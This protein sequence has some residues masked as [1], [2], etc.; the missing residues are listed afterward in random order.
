MQ[1]Y[2]R[3]T[4]DTFPN[5]PKK[6]NILGDNFCVIYTYT[7]YIDNN[8]INIFCVWTGE[9]YRKTFSLLRFIVIIIYWQLTFYWIRLYALVLGIYSL[10]LIIQKFYKLKLSIGI[11]CM[12]HTIYLCV[13][14]T[15]NII[16]LEIN[17]TGWL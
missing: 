15:M 6:Y 1:H 8:N 10:H 3:R 14:H 9:Y 13:C 17:L 7:S 12:S 11:I 4:F 16:W 2:V 5:I